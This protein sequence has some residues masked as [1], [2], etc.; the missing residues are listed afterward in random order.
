MPGNSK[1]MQV[2]FQWV[3][4]VVMVVVVQ[5]P[6]SLSIIGYFGSSTQSNMVC[7]ASFVQKTASKCPSL[8]CSLCA[9]I[10]GKLCQCPRFGEIGSTL[11]RFLEWP[12]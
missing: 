6:L 12:M 9:Q 3:V 1:I 2:S 4:V 8:A 7:L 10:F 5:T 11:G